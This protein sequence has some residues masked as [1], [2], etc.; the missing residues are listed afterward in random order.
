MNTG[1]KRHDGMTPGRG[2]R[3]EARQLVVK[4]TLE[5]CDVA[6]RRSSWAQ[7]CLLIFAEPGFGNPSNESNLY[8]SGRLFGD[9]RDGAP[10]NDAETGTKHLDL[11]L[12]SLHWPE[13]AES[14]FLRTHKIAHIEDGAA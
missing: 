6:W 3:Q 13:L 10:A 12:D 1:R 8:R 11:S 9:D 7:R 5:Q 2:G 4:T 14:S